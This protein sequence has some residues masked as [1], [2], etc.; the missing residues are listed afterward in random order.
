MAQEIREMTTEEV[1][2]FDLEDLELLL[3]MATEELEP[4]VA[5]GTAYSDLAP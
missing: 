1:E 2:T 4:R 3:E 5:P